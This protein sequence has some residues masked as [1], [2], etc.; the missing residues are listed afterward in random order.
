MSEG[1]AVKRILIDIVWMIVGGPDDIYYPGTMSKSRKEC[2]ETFC[3][4][5]YR[6]WEALKK[7]GFR[8]VRVELCEIGKK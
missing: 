3:E 7:R 1:R 4:F 2:I 5:R 8:C 6:K